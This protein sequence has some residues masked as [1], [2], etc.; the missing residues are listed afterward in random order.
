MYP[1]LSG[2]KRK[3]VTSAI[4]IGTIVWITSVPIALYMKPKNA[5]KFWNAGIVL[6]KNEN[7]GL[8]VYTIEGI[9]KCHKNHVRPFLNDQ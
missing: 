7:G 4:N 1:T 6:E 2:F 9:Q 5:P 3:M 8:Q